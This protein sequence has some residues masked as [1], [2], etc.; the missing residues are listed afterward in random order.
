MKKII[1]TVVAL[2]I[3]LFVIV[4][5]YEFVFNKPIIESPTVDEYQA[6]AQKVEVKEQQKGSMYT[7]AGEL[8]LPTPCHSLTTKVNKISDTTYQIEI[9]TVAPAA[10]VMCAQVITPKPYKVSFEAGENITVTVL[11][12]GVE[13]E[14]NRFLIPDGANIDTFKLEIKG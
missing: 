7:F 5:G 3:A 2:V 4:Y 14:T 12:D 13:Y 10:D 1:I 6:P 11:L 9:N 8:D